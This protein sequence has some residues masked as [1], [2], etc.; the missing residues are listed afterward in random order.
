MSYANHFDALFLGLA[1]WLP[2]FFWPSLRAGF[3]ASA[4]TLPRLSLEGFTSSAIGP[5][6]TSLSFV[7]ME[8]RRPSPVAGIIGTPGFVPMAERRC[9]NLLWRFLAISSR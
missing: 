8:R 6:Q 1:S 5:A 9:S 4:L 2:R 7:P 3:W